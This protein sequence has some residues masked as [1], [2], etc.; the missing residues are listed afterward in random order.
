MGVKT[1][2]GGSMKSF[3]RAVYLGR[4]ISIPSDDFEPTQDGEDNF[5]DDTS[6]EGQTSKIR[7]PRRSTNFKQHSRG[8]HDRSL[9]LA[10]A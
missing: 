6:Q 4:S 9:H 1:H 10:S 7:T 3:R 8:K 2:Y 5:D